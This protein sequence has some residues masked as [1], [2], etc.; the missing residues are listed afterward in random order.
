MNYSNKKKLRFSDFKKII[1]YLHNSYKE[2]LAEQ[3]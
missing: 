1:S 3:E 2:T